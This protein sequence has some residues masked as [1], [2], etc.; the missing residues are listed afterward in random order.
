ME[1][2]KDCDIHD[3][4]ITGRFCKVFGHRWIDT[5][6]GILYPS[7]PPQYPAKQRNCDICGK[8]QVKKIPEWEDI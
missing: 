4:G 7:Y 5:T 1:D 8:G 2:I 6:P 3:L